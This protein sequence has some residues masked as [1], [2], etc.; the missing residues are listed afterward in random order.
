MSF[1][2]Q[3]ISNFTFF[4]LIDMDAMFPHIIRPKFYVSSV[5]AKDEYINVS[6]ATISTQ[7]IFHNLTMH[8]TT[9]MSNL[10]QVFPFM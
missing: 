7:G 1:Q 8:I 2:A 3:R 9:M 10:H 5:A 4:M 6:Q